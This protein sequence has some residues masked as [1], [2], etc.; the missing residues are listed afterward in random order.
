MISII[1]DTIN[2]KK[3]ICFD[4]E[5]WIKIYQYCK[6][7]SKDGRFINTCR[8]PDMIPKGCSWGECNEKV[9]PYFN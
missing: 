6:I 3:Y 9:C 8:K 7:G 2:D 5:N 4:Y 1:R